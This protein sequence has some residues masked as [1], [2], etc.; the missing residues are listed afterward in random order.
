MQRQGGHRDWGKW[1]LLKQNI[2]V[3]YNYEE[4]FWKQI[5]RVQWIKECDKNTK[6]FHA[7]TMQRKKKN[8]V[9]MQVSEQGQ[10]CTTD[11]E[12]EKKIT[13]FYGTL[14]T[15]SNPRN[16]QKTIE[17]LSSTISVT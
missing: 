16:W 3:A 4:V 13:D 15:T 7:Y 14:F 17:G 5:S 12:I 10:V 8:S 9:E 1:N 11:S 6:F 2:A